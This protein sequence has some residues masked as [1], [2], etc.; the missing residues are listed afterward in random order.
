MTE[1]IR[2][3]SIRLRK[4][5]NRTVVRNFL[6]DVEAS[7]IE[8]EYFDHYKEVVPEDFVGSDGRTYS[9]EDHGKIF[10]MPVQKLYDEGEK[11]YQFPRLLGCAWEIS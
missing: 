7:S 9:W 11:L 2:C 3:V 8:I 4:V 1:E 5:P 10:Y 6:K